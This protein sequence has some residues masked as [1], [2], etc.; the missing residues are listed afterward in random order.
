[1]LA[2]LVNLHARA[3]IFVLE[4]GLSVVCLENLLEVLRELGKHRQQRNEELNIDLLEAS[5]AFGQRNRCD[6]G[7]VGEK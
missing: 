1:L 6:L 7:E 3:V 4:R 5:L 2:I